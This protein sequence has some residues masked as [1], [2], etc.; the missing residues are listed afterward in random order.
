MTGFNDRK[1]R[2]GHAHGTGMVQNKKIA[3]VGSAVSGDREV[4]RRRCQDDV[5]VTGSPATTPPGRPDG[6]RLAR[7]AGAR[8]VC[9]DESMPH[10]R[11]MGRH[12]AKSRRSLAIHG[13]R[14][15]EALHGL[16]PEDLKVQKSQDLK[17]CRPSDRPFPGGSQRPVTQTG[18]PGRR[19]AARS[20]TCMT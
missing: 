3:G 20:G 18:N 10:E 5:R 15:E 14:P 13:L 19:Q 2:P 17:I 6:S 9:R 16:G 11:N 12:T 7:H 8:P 1:I 4:Q